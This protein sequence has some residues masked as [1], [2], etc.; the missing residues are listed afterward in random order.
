V[1]GPCALEEGSIEAPAEGLGGGAGITQGDGSVLV[2]VSA[3][4]TGRGVAATMLGRGSSSRFA[5]LSGWVLP[6]DK[7]A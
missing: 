3:L 1:R 5:A 4:G 2:G 6:D 7:F